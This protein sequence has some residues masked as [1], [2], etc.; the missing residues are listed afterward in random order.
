LIKHFE[1]L[2]CPKCKSKLELAKKS[3]LIYKD[4]NCKAIFPIINGVPILINDSSSIFKVKDFVQGTNKALIYKK[5][6]LSKL[7]KLVPKSGKNLKAKINYPKFK[8]LLLKDTPKPKILVIGSGGI[9]KGL[10]TI[11]NDPV[12]EFIEMFCFRR[13][14]T[15]PLDRLAYN[16]EGGNGFGERSSMRTCI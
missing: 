1:L 13:N 7:R 16:L 14:W 9:G 2:R 15:F 3:Y 11:I 5:S 4:E 10:K 8:S 6:I 12:I